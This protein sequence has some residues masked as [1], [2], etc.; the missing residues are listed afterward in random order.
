MLISSD[1][2]ASLDNDLARL[3]NVFNLRDTRESERERGE[4]ERE[5]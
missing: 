2:L 1:C 3:L 5:R 4:R